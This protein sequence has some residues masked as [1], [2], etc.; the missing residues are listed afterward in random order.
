MF[1][2]FGF[3]IFDF[4][5]WDFGF[6]GFGLWVSGVVFWVL[7]FVCLALGF[8]SQQPTTNQPPLGPN[9]PTARCPGDNSCC[10]L[11]SKESKKQKLKVTVLSRYYC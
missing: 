3:S 6:M 7:G 5:F 9:L 2:T 4:W 11:K 1:W 8:N 10:R